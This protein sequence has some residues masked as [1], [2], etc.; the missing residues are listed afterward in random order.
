MSLSQFLTRMRRSKL[1]IPSQ[2]CRRFM[3][4]PTILKILSISIYEPIMPST[5]Q[6]RNDTCGNF[7]TCA[8]H[9]TKKF[10]VFVDCTHNHWKI[11][12]LFFNV[13]MMASLTET[14]CPKKQSSSFSVVGFVVVF[15]GFKC[16]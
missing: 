15:I 13:D 8:T 1:S 6:N 12:N 14:I 7:T 11:C 10:L 16:M 9:H 5:W 2:D 3:M 4:T